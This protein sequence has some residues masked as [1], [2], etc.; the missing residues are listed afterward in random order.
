MSERR[1]SSTISPPP[2]RSRRRRPGRIPACAR[3][4]GEVITHHSGVS[5][6]LPELTITG[7]IQTIQG[8]SLPVGWLPLE[9]VLLKSPS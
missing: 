1:A 9:A 6:S 8:G 2:P 5:D 3:A 7:D 4:E